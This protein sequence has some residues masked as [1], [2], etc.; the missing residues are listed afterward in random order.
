[1]RVNVLKMKNFLVDNGTNIVE[2]PSQN[3]VNIKNI[4]EAAKAV[5]GRKASFPYPLDGLIF[6][7][8]DE[9][10]FSRNIYKWKDEPTIDFYYKGNKLHLAG[11]NGSGKEYM[12]LPFEGYDGKGSFRTNTKVVKNEI[13]TDKVAPENVRKGLLKAPIP[14]DPGVGE[15]KFE[16]NTFK[17]VR[18]R[19]DKTFPNGVESSNQVW[20][21]ISNPLLPKE[22]FVGP[23]AMRDY[24]SEIKSKLIMK[25]AKGK[26]VIDIGSGKGEDVSK[27]VK[28]ESKPVVGFDIVEEEYP[29][30][31]YMTFHKVPSETYK[32]KNYVKQKYDVININFAIHY[33]LKNKKTF[34]SLVMNIHENLKKGGVIMATVLDGK[35]VYQSLKNKNIVNTNKYT[36]TKKYNNSLNFNSPKFKMLGQEVEVLVKGTKYFNK[37]IS[38]FLFNFD[39]FLRIMEEL[40]FELVEKGN[41]S[42]FCSESEWCR[43]YM[44]D[45]EK[46]YSFKNIYFVLRKK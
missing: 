2:Y 46:D 1:M 36:F 19:P 15:F 9:E 34:E 41:F 40:G 7:P 35:L 16:D 3:P 8:T 30:P 4:Y 31:N 25:Y 20:E 14:G 12:V 10:Y 18:K 42:E 28:A 45:A 17:L 39:K 32:I 24:H 26:S 29:H 38:E 6:T 44:T 5:W 22:L 21:S 43:R 23:G 33:F 37:P 11:F 27:Y 13:F